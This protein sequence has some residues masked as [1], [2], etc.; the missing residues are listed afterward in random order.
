MMKLFKCLIF[1]SVWLNFKCLTHSLNHLRN[2]CHWIWVMAS[3]IGL[4]NVLLCSL[5]KNKVIY[6]QLS[7]VDNIQ[8]L[9]RQYMHMKSYPLNK[10][11]AQDFVQQ[12]PM[13]SIKQCTRQVAIIL[14]TTYRSGNLWKNYQSFARFTKIFISFSSIIHS[15]NPINI[16]RPVVNT[17]F[18]NV[19]LCNRTFWSSSVENVS[20][21][22]SKVP[23]RKKYAHY[24]I[25]YH[26]RKMQLMDALKDLI[27]F[28]FGTSTDIVPGLLELLLEVS[29]QQGGP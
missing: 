25:L 19:S 23:T 28:Q 18:E 9:I 22:F 27:T 21:Q 20:F 3:P 16:Q 24:V 10:A 6:F 1:I 17:F 26:M 14:P 11:L 15:F 29:E 12:V 7:I 8:K 5:L 13:S 4:C 2:S